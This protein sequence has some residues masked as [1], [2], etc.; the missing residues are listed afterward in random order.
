MNCS[1]PDTNTTAGSARNSAAY[2][3]SIPAPSS[4]SCDTHMA[5]A[6]VLADTAR[7][8]LPTMPRLVALR[9][10]TNV[11]EPLGSSSRNGASIASKAP[12]SSPGVASSTITTSRSW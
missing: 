3:A 5:N 6:P 10:S 8:Q 12:A 7:F 4:S 2:A 1:A 9:D 11:H